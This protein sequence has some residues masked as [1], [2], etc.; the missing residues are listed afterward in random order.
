MR[1]SPTTREQPAEEPDPEIVE[2][3]T[4]IDDY[5]GGFA[6]TP[7]TDGSGVSAFDE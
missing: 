2:R 1:P 5:L 4:A 3:A 6:P 7:S